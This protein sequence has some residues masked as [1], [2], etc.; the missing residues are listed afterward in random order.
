VHVRH[1]APMLTV[2]LLL[3]NAA[4]AQT[5]DAPPAAGWGVT[6]GQ[7]WT[8]FFLLLG[9][10]KIIA[11]FVGLTRGADADFVR[12]LALRGAAFAAAVLFAA[13]LVGVRML[14]NFNM[15]PAVLT[16]AGGIIV[17]LVALRAL[18]DQI[19]GAAPANAA[20]PGAPGPALQSAFSPLAFPIIVTPAGIAAV[21]VFTA[22]APDWNS[23]LV[24]IALLV[25]VLALDLCAMLF[26]RQI[27]RWAA[28]PLQVFGAVLG[29]IQLALG[30]HIILTALH[31]LAVIAY[32]SQ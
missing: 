22:L 9:P 14:D 18:L 28:M 15:K 27:L 30:L 23:K 16:L 10:I 8:F 25:L 20:A 17:F 2:G 26:A 21:I 6:P 31:T 11:P 5:V 19:A 3:G 1:L 13:V 24:I 12:R 7:I 32:R 4:W 29:I